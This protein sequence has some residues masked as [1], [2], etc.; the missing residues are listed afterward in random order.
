MSFSDEDTII[1]FLADPELDSEAQESLAGPSLKGSSGGSFREG[2]S[3]QTEGQAFQEANWFNVA[4]DRLGRGPNK[5]A[6]KCKEGRQQT[7]ETIT[8]KPG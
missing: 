6:A 5:Y 8:L 4:A 7:R 2:C 3:W 1:D